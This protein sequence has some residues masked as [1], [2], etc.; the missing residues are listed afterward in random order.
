MHMHLARPLVTCGGGP[1]A[2]GVKSLQAAAQSGNV[3]GMSNILILSTATALPGIAQF[4]RILV[5]A[6]FN[7][8]AVSPQNSLL[9]ESRHLTVNARLRGTVDLTSLL[10]ALLGV[11]RAWRY[12]LIIPG[13]DW[14]MRHLVQL[15]DNCDSGQIS[16]PLAEVIRR[17]VVPARWRRT[18]E[19]KTLLLDLADRLGVRTAPRIKPASADDVR[20]FCRQH[21]LPVVVKGEISAS[22]AG[23]FIADSVERA[24]DAA[25]GRTPPG[26]RAPWEP[27]LLSVQRMIRGAAASVTFASLGGRL[28]G[29]FCYVA[30]ACDPPGV[31]SATV[32]RTVDRPDMIEAATRIAAELQFTGFAG[33]DFILEEG[34]G[35]AWLLEMNARPPQTAHL[36]PLVGSD[37]CAAFRAALKGEPPP[38]PRPATA[39]MVVAL[40][41]AEWNRDPASPYLASAHHPVPWDDR[42]LLAAIVDRSARQVRPPS[43][44]APAE[45]SFL[46]TPSL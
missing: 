20:A 12:E 32:I 6:G 1:A 46:M 5:E 13:D 40:F 15:A 43:G 34:G 11:A 33:F 39:D 10:D 44:R 36:G 7:V 22:G 28:L 19:R 23:V 42:G 8:G 30:E 31:G 3:G 4:P 14:A 17:S 38:P 25:L 26:I 9:A 41:P 37:L 45:L 24:V 27:E 2:A 21:G 29:G 18:V 35:P 16:G